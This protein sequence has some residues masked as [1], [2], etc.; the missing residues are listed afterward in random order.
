[1]IYLTNFLI[2]LRQIKIISPRRASLPNRATSSPYERPLR[3]GI[4]KIMGEIKVK[5]LLRFS[6][7]KTTNLSSYSTKGTLH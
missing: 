2:E 5:E 7:I 6:Q 4:R 3:E 1:M